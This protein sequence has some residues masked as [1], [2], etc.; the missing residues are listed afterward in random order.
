M[1]D[2][3]PYYQNRR[4]RTNWVTILCSEQMKSYAPTVLSSSSS[5]TTTTTPSET[6]LR[7]QGKQHKH[8]RYLFNMKSSSVHHRVCVGNRRNSH[9]LACFPSKEGKE[10][11]VNDN[12]SIHSNESNDRHG[13]DDYDDI[14][15]GHST[16]LDE[17]EEIFV[18]GDSQDRQ[19]KFVSIHADLITSSKSNTMKKV[20][21]LF[22]QHV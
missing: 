5:S 7:Q 13:D 11:N 9:L 8:P 21:L 15:S 18:L 17:V 1:I 20:Q 10:Y 2:R 4:K 16:R 22:I 6:K 14:N 19:H 3:N 12:I